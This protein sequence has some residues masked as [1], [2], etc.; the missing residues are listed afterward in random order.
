MVGPNDIEN[1][2]TEDEMWNRDAAKTHLGQETMVLQSEDGGEADLRP[3]FKMGSCA[4]LFGACFERLMV[5][6]TEGGSDDDDGLSSSLPSC[7]GLMIDIARLRAERGRCLQKARDLH[8]YEGSSGGNNTQNLVSI[9]RDHPGKVTAGGKRVGH[10]F[11]KGDWNVNDRNSS[12]KNKKNTR[13]EKKK[14]AKS[15]HDRED[16]TVPLIRSERSG[17]RREE[18]LMERGRKHRKNKK[19]QNRDAALYEFAYSYST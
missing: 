18:K 14:S 2:T 19:K 12:G 4:A 17:K 13:K 5:R 15:N 7:L 3:V 16:V 11:S 6:L 1:V 8:L 10:V 9:A